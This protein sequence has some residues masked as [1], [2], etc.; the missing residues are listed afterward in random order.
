MSY[1]A[2]AVII[3]LLLWQLGVKNSGGAQDIAKRQIA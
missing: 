3:L 2:Y 1:F